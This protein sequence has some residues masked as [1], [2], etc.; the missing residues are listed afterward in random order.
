VDIINFASDTTTIKLNINRTCK[1]YITNHK[2]DTFTEIESYKHKMA[3][4]VLKEWFYGGS[5]ETNLG[6]IRPNRKC[7]VWFE[8]PIVKNN[9]YNSIE[10]NWDEI[11]TNPKITDDMS[12]EDKQKLQDE[13][14]P[15][16]NECLEIGIYPKRVIDI[17]L[18]HKGVPLWFIEICHTNPTSQSKINE[19]KILGVTNL[20]EID[21]E[22]IMKQTKKP[23][24]LKYKQLI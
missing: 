6:Y 13:Y 9:D 15:T 10:S 5:N 4:E 1:L 23:K 22:W 8:Y 16:Y 3:K 7:G 20:I 12:D 18:T 17:V 11:L 2:M 21:A 19:L 14:V 24:E